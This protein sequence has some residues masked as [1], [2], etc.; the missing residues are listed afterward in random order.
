M[1]TAFLA[2]GAL[3]ALGCLPACQTTQSPSGGALR[4]NQVTGNLLSF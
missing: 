1:K 2:A 4:Y 3:L